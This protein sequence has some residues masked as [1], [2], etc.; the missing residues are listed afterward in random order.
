MT[1]QVKI[2]EQ[3][4]RAADI[5]RIDAQRDPKR[6]TIKQR[7]EHIMK[8]G[9]LLQKIEGQDEAT[10]RANNRTADEESSSRRE[11]SNEEDMRN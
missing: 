10:C 4:I 2:I 5:I 9:S 1:E 6:L 8:L 11:Q 7:A 3:I